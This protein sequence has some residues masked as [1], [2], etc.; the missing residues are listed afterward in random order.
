MQYNVNLYP[1]YKG[2]KFRGIS[3]LLAFT[4]HCQRLKNCIHKNK[5]SATTKSNA[6]LS[7][8]SISTIKQIQNWVFTLS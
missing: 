4:C 3:I 6:F 5:S 1:C 8:M 7:F 2:K